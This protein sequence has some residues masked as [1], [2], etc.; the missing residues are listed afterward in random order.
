MSTPL[1]YTRTQVA[2]HWS[3]FVLLIVSFFSHEG[4]KRAFGTFLRNG[5]AEMSTGAYVH[6]I[7]GIIILALVVWRIVLR[8]TNT[9]PPEP[10][11]GLLGLAAK[12][13]QFIL[14]A[15]LVILPVSGLIAWFGGVHDAGDVHEVM[16][17]I[18]WLLVALHIIAALVHQF[19]WKDNLLARM[20]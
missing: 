18:G 2:L 10:K 15:V 6:I 19:Y 11:G 9:A 4:M 8:I 1:K 20:K 5:T 12:A 7:V 14:Y 13:V 3:V 16:F 17:T